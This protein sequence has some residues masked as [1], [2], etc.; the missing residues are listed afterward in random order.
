[1]T[2]IPA[3]PTSSRSSESL[4]EDFEKPLVFVRSAHC[5]PQTLA[6]QPAV[7]MQIFYQNTGFLQRQKNIAR[8]VLEQTNQDE[9]GMSVIDLTIGAG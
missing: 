6:Q 4:T 8:I 7:R 9:V 1:M 2:L 5:D 3:Y